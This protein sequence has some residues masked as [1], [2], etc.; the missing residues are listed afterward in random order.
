M[1]LHFRFSLSSNDAFVLISNVLIAESSSERT[2]DAPCI[3]VPPVML[4]FVLLGAGEEVRELLR[5]EGMLFDLK[6]EIREPAADGGGFGTGA[7]I[8][9]ALGLSVKALFAGVDEEGGRGRLAM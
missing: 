3:D 5:E 8:A 9:S 2:V 7:W 6:S 4:T 1:Q